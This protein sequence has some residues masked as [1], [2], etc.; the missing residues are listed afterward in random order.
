MKS[1]DTL[2]VQTELSLNENIVLHPNEGFDLGLMSSANPVKIFYNVT[3]DVFNKGEDNF[4]KG[5][6]LLENKCKHGT[7]K[8]G[9]KH[10]KKMVSPLKIKLVI[11]KSEEQ[12]SAFLFDKI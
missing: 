4:I 3:I 6:L 8:I 9:N 10:W 11:L 7:I 12:F 5:S 2:L 1:T